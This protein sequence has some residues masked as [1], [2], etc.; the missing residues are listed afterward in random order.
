[1][2]PESAQRWFVPLSEKELTLSQALATMENITV[3]QDSIPLIVQL[4]EN[5]KYQIGGIEIFSGA[6]DLTT[7]DYIHL[8]LGRGIMPKDEAFV[9]GFTMGST[10]KMKHMEEQVYGL[11][12]RYLYPRDYRFS[13][14]DYQIYKNA[15]RL[16]F[17]S[18][19]QPL[20]KVDY[21]ALADLSLEEIRHQLGIETNLLKAYY[22][23]EKCRHPNNMECQRL[24]N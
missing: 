7:H 22:E 16:A 12:A 10:N 23:I 21:V 11:F 4:V 20:N 9:L 19:C 5:P 3:G 14:D 6:A 18:G 2:L 8:I 24:L 17:I 15:V 13:Q 1:M